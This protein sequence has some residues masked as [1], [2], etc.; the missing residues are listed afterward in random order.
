MIGCHDLHP[1][2]HT[3]GFWKSQSANYRRR[4]LGV[5]SYSSVRILEGSS[6]YCLEEDRYSSGKNL[7]SPREVAS[8]L[9]GV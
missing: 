3:N 6:W 2:N 7:D 1:E 8:I 4:N 5:I 9:A